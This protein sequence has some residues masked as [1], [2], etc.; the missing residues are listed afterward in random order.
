MPSRPSPAT[1]VVQTTGRTAPGANSTRSCDLFAGIGRDAPQLWIGQLQWR[2][3]INAIISIVIYLVGGWATPLKNMKV[4]WDYDI[5][6]IW[7]N[8]NVPNHQPAINEGWPHEIEMG[9][10][11]TIWF[12]KSPNEMD[13][14]LQLRK[15]MNITNLNG[16]S[17][18]KNKGRKVGSLEILR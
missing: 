13:R 5:S 1:A 18:P 3:L 15:S 12:R 17:P 4:S 10:P 8:K 14:G 11:R 6:N 2:S 9:N 7:N 16:K